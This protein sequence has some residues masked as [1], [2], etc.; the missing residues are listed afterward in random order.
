MPILGECPSELD[1]GT[2]L[3]EAPFHYVCSSRSYADL[4]DTPGKEDAP[5]GRS[6]VAYARRRGRLILVATEME[7]PTSH[8]AEQDFASLQ[9]AIRARSKVSYVVAV[10]LF[11]ALSLLSATTFGTWWWWRDFLDV[12]RQVWAILALVSGGLALEM[13]AGIIW[14]RLNIQHAIETANG[15][16]D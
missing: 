12:S 7:A 15:S 9:E 5:V 3:M 16:I 1:S 6:A 14:L 13:A 11:C 8:R 4:E 2:G 10:S